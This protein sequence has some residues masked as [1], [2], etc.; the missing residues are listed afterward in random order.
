MPRILTVVGLTEEPTTMAQ[1]AGSE[2][3]TSSVSGDSA[4][5]GDASRHKLLPFGWLLFTTVWLL[6][7]VGFV[8]QV[9]RTTDL[10]PLQL[11][12]LLTSLAAFISIFLWLM[13]RYPFPTSG[14]TPRELRVRIGLLLTMA[15][16]ALY[17]ERAYGSGVPYRFMYVVIAAAVTLPAL[18]ATWMV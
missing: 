5:I 18:K 11:L 4:G 10:Y 15:V 13:L 8:I 6:F 1:A 17:V 12:T 9:L 14:L 3:P 2:Q 16:L 7:P